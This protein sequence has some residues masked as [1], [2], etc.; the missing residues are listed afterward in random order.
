M[1][2]LLNL[3]AIKA[4]MGK[5]LAEL[6]QDRTGQHLRCP[7]HQPD[8]TGSL[9]I[10]RGDDGVALWRCM[11]GCGKGTIIDAMAINRKTTSRGA[12]K[13]LAE[14]LGVPIKH[15]KLKPPPVI[16]KTRAKSLIERAHGNLI[17]S[18]EIQER[19]M[20]GKRGIRSLDLMRKHRIGFL[21]GGQFPEWRSWLIVGWVLPITD[22]GGILCAVKIHSEIRGERM[23]KCM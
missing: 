7:F 15:S 16:N 8:S 5:L 19:W 18:P 2:A 11:A 3:D 14:E 23:P 21:D 6:G 9:C 1:G 20:A 12:I 13:A 10:W 22:A 17:G 4:D